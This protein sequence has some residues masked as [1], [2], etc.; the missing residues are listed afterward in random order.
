M[1]SITKAAL[2]LGLALESGS[3]MA[4]DTADVPNLRFHQTWIEAR[5]TELDV[6]DPRG[7]FAAIFARIPDAA[8]VWPTENYF[9]FS[10]TANG[11]DYGGNFRL[12][13]DERD[14]GLIHFAY[15]DSGDPAWF[16]HLLLGPD[17]GVTLK[18]VGD[19]AYSM[20]F[21]DRTVTFALNTITQERPGPPLVLPDEGYVG[22]SFDESGLTFVLVFMPKG[23]QFAWVLDEAQTAEMPLYPVAPGLDLHVPSGFVFATFPDDARRI[24]VG[25]DA[26]QVARNTW[27]DGPFDQLPDNWLAETPFRDYLAAA[28]PG[29][30][31]MVNARGE[32]PGGESRFAVMPYLHYQRLEDVWRRSVSCA[33]PQQS[34]AAAVAC[35]A[36]QVD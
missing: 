7:V 30:S 15:F 28:S 10:F 27:F 16:K 11:R 6:E 23:R 9:Y 18:K 20:T 14:R 13:P 17:D 31:Q 8:H 34:V 21:A 33:A 24:L 29:I 35:F 22:R 2:V 3:A 26:G 5:Q 1:R 19:L 32:Y 25:V 36:A 12:H 4:A